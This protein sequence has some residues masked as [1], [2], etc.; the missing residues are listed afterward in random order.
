[1]VGIIRGVFFCLSLCYK[2]FGITDIYTYDFMYT[3]R[4]SGS[5]SIYIVVV[6][7][8]YIYFFLLYFS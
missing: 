3:R 4:S 8:I 2:G 1:M 6:V 5:S 7:S